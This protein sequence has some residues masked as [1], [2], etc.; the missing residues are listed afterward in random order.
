M[1]WV[2][3]RARLE[4]REAVAEG[5]H[6]ARLRVEE[7]TARS[8]PGADPAGPAAASEASPAGHAVPAAV[9]GQFVQLNL[10]GAFWPRPFSLLDW[11]AGSAGAAGFQVLF[12]EAGPATRALAALPPGAV[13]AGH[14]PLGRGFPEPTGPTW[15]IAG[16][17]GVAP[18]LFAA[19]R[20]PQPAEVRLFYGAA[21]AALLWRAPE[22]RRYL[23]TLCTED[24]SLGTPGT[25]LDAVRAALG[26]RAAGAGGG[27]PA[28]GAGPALFA[29]GPM[30][31]LGATAALAREAGLE[32]HV[33][34]EA[35]MPCGVGVCRGC[36]V[37]LAAPAEPRYAMACEDGPVFDAR[38]IDWEA[39]AA[40]RT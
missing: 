29:C 14:G 2:R 3:F 32:A 6:V 18:L 16:G 27:A 15:M 10:P 13:L 4:A 23:H 21:R 26:P 33:S 19:R 39:E 36:A 38:R 37:P 22:L 28:A 1:A 12:F 5:Q 11:Q 35:P 17:Y 40:C 8:A 31:L 7:V 25:V 9:P 34:V 30:G 24:G 20:A